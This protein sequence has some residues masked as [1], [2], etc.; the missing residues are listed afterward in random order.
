M[1]A[2]LQYSTS[3]RF[4]ERCKKADKGLGNHTCYFRSRVEQ[5]LQ[6]CL[7]DQNNSPDFN[8]AKLLDSALA[9]IDWRSLFADHN[10]QRDGRNGVAATALT[11]VVDA[12]SGALS[13]SDH[14]EAGRVLLFQSWAFGREAS[15]NQSAVWSPSDELMCNFL[16]A[17]GVVS[18]PNY[19]SKSA[20]ILNL[21]ALANACAARVSCGIESAFTIGPCP[22][23]QNSGDATDL[24][25]EYVSQA[26]SL[27]QLLKDLHHSTE[28]EFDVSHVMMLVLKTLDDVDIKNLELLETVDKNH[29]RDRQVQSS[30]SN[31]GSKK[32]QRL[33]SGTRASD[34]VQAMHDTPLD[35]GDDRHHRA[36][37]TQREHKNSLKMQVSLKQVLNAPSA[38]K[39]DSQ[40]AGEATNESNNR[41]DGILEAYKQSS[42]ITT[43]TA[44]AAYLRRELYLCLVEQDRNSIEKYCCV[45]KDQQKMIKSKLAQLVSALF[46]RLKQ[47]NSPSIRLY[48]VMTLDHLRE[49]HLGDRG[50]LH[51]MDCLY[52]QG[53]SR[54]DKEAFYL[55]MYTEIASECDVYA[56]PRRLVAALSNLVDIALVHCIK[57]RH[58]PMLHAIGHIL[59]RRRHILSRLGGDEVKAY[60]RLMVKMSIEF[61]EPSLWISQDRSRSENEEL[62]AIL[63]S[64][65]VLSLM[66]VYN[67][68]VAHGNTTVDDAHS[69]RSDFSSL[70]STHTRLGPCQGFNK[71]LTNLLKYEYVNEVKPPSSVTVDTTENISPL[72]NMDHNGVLHVVFDFLGYRSLTRASMCC[73]AWKSAACSNRR[74][75]RLYF[76]KFKG[77]ILE[78]ELNVFDF[79]DFDHRWACN[80]DERIKYPM[81]REGYDWFIIFKDNYISEKFAR[82]HA[83]GTKWHRVCP[84]VGCGTCIVSEHCWNIHRN[85]HVK[86]WQT[87]TKKKDELQALRAKAFKL[88]QALSPGLEYSN[89]GILPDST[90]SKIDCPESVL[91]LIF[92]FLD[93][94]DLVRPV[95]KL[96]TEQIKSLWYQIYCRDFGRPSEKWFSARRRQC[97]WKQMFEDKYRK[98]RYLNKCGGTTNLGFRVQICSVPGCPATLHS[99]LDLDLHLVRHEIRWL[100]SNE[101]SRKKRNGRSR[102]SKP[103]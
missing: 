81:S 88:N 16:G 23:V 46:S 57:G 47:F 72:S 82:R 4:Y 93:V 58:K 5:A 26:I 89:A 85:S 19:G 24:R 86:Q 33:P 22:N 63:K 73:K 32:R 84:F 50:Y 66:H 97:Y 56:S 99:K 10:V 64:C 27:M 11:G 61:D 52:L 34:I 83:V 45:G 13:E 35:L 25:K 91:N 68:E 43:L 39:D 98:R 49:L 7:E 42:R 67:S 77:A 53:Y 37:R 79:R 78:E 103:K 94:T 76:H 28:A 29:K 90:K 65:G 70:R 59:L 12:F 21:M 44:E 41:L 8:T 1:L 101:V 55:E 2:Q 74:W 62:V 30:S 51:F 54:E 100:E 20:A 80:L 15:N 36:K 92:L 18:S 71:I 87:S 31:S 40:T 60:Q 6:Q 9:V 3:L 96:W 75:C 48:T 38:I 17:P 95:C 69:R 102:L 14:D